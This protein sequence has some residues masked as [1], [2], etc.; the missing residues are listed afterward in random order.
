M[1]VSRRAVIDQPVCTL[2]CSE[3]FGNQ[4]HCDKEHL[5]WHLKQEEVLVLQLLRTTGT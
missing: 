2:S 4:C 3:I 5:T 1:V